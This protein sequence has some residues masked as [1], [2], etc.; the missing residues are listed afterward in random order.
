[1]KV[2]FFDP[3]LMARSEFIYRNQLIQLKETDLIMMNDSLKQV[4]EEEAKRIAAEKAAM[5]NT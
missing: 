2:P 3:A 1:V 4:E 5:A